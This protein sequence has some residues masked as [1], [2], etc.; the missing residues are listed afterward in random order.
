MS[1]RYGASNAEG[2]RGV[3]SL[4]AL[5]RWLLPYMISATSQV[6]DSNAAAA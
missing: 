4:P 3:I 2:R 6:P 1:G 5:L